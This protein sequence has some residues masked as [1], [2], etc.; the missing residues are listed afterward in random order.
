MTGIGFAGVIGGVFVILVHILPLRRRPFFCGIVS[1]IES[2]AV[3]AAPIIGGT[4]TESLGWRWRFWINLP[5]GSIT[6]L[7]IIFLFSD[8]KP[9]DTSLT[10]MQKLIELDPLSNLFF[11]PALTSLF[12]ALSWAGTKY[13]WDDGKV[14]GPLVAFIILIAAFLYN[15]HRRGDNTALPPRIMKNRS[16]IAAAVFTMCTNSAVNV[17][18]YY[19]PTYY[20]VVRGYS[21]SKSGYMMIPIVVGSTIGSFL[22]GSGTSTT[23]YYA[24]S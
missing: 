17:L 23:G 16:V 3:L 9:S 19:L 7:M 6:L 18:E 2:A 5:I 24:L 14:I 12:I 4:L 1:V 15:Q 8:P 10:F 21:P 13:S 22:C 20:Q 11:V